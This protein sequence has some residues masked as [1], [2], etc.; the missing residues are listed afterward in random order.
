MI[1]VY[2]LTVDAER[3]AVAATPGQSLM[4]AAV[5]AGVPGILADC[6]GSCACATCHV[7]IDDAW[8]PRVDAP[9]PGEDAL[10][11]TRHDREP[12][13]RLACQLRLDESCA[14]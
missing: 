10:L 12:T 3:L 5:G 9:N 7:Y 1:T 11:S 4:E 6:G 8:W 14:A 2:F 13:S